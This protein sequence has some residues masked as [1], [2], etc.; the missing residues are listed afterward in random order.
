MA[1]MAESERVLR[2]AVVR[3]AAA[4]AVALAAEP[5]TWPGRA[6]RARHLKLFQ[7]SVQELG[8]T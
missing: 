7:F 2:A 4:T 8:V 6:G 5:G 1:A 3:K